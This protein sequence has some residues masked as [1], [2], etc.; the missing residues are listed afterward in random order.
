MG[1]A[2]ENQGKTMRPAAER[3]ARITDF[4]ASRNAPLATEGD[5]LV[6]LS[7]NA[8]LVVI[9]AGD[10]LFAAS[11]IEGKPGWQHFVVLCGVCACFVDA[12]VQY[13]G[14]LPNEAVPFMVGDA[15]N[16]LFAG[17]DR[18]NWSDTKKVHGLAVKEYLHLI[19]S[20]EMKPHIDALGAAFYSYLDS[21]DAEDFEVMLEHFKALM[22]NPDIPADMQQGEA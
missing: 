21:H 19:E 9:I 20:E 6:R 22:A 15:V 2:T 12:V 3:A 8:T 10:D 4:L 18:K 7:S 1:Q 5:P 17:P 16:F 14:T 13:S 11:G